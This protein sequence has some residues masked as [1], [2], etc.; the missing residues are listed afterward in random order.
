MSIFLQKSTRFDS[1][2]LLLL[3]SN[4]YCENLQ[5][6]PLTDAQ[7]LL[8]GG[9]PYEICHLENSAVLPQNIP[10]IKSSPV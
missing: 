4:V 9:E 7:K 3:K 6:Q 1:G 2:G 8:N 5:K 10:E